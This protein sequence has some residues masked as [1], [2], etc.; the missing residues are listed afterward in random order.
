VGPFS[1]N[2]LIA[3]I[4]SMSKLFEFA[5]FHCRS[6]LINWIDICGHWNN[7]VCCGVREG[8]FANNLSGSRIMSS[9]SVSL[10]GIKLGRWDKVLDRIIRSPGM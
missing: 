4:A 8:I 2:R 10:S 6:R 9:L 5:I 3:S 1:S 7:G